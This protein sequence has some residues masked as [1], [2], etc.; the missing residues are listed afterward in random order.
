MVSSMC[1]MCITQISHIQEECQLPAVAAMKDP[2][3]RQA[4]VSMDYS[5][6]SRAIQFLTGGLN[7]QS[8]HHLLPS[9][10]LCHYRT[11]YPK[12]VAICRKHDCEPPRTANLVTCFGKHLLYVFRLGYNHPRLAPVVVEGGRGSTI[13]M[14]DGDE[15]GAPGGTS[16]HTQV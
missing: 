9:V 5:T 1:F 16:G 6:G 12:F 14:L 7:L 4:M 15:E 8:L 11:L 3:M 13:Q 10:S 2:F